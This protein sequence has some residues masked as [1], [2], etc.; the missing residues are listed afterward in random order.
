MDIS[1]SQL[2]AIWK[3]ADAAGFFDAGWVFDHFYPPRGQIRPMWEGWTVLTALAAMTERLRLGVMVSS[4]TF[5]H[6]AL[7]AHMAASVDQL[8]VGRLE[9]GLGAGWHQEEHAAFGI[10]LG[11][12]EQRWGRLGEAL[13]IIDGL[14]TRD[15]FS[16]AGTHFTLAD[17]SLL[18]QG[19]QQPRP[20]LVIGGI[21][22]KRTMPLVARW[23]DHW[24]YFNPTEPP[25]ALSA[26][27]GRLQELCE[28]VGRDPGE[29]EV[30]VQIRN[31]ATPAELT[32]VAGSYLEAGA[33]HILVTSF[34]P[35]NAD[36]VP[37]IAAALAPLR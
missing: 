26:H 15:T 13:E 21:G 7:L 6:P 32:D 28:Q 5:R 18:Q 11:T 33:D 34:P 29:I 36:T 3:E 27:H 10:D 30:S 37:T 25:E 1:W 2:S 9:I 14:L 4:N 8:S 12:A 20:P 23:A 17:A 19:V 31:P 24:N 35:V 22:P 16:F